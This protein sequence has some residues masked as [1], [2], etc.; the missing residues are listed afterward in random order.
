MWYYI[1]ISNY[2]H[3]YFYNIS[4]FLGFHFYCRK[5]I[6]MTWRKQRYV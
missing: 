1:S 3:I 2:F 6:F 4:T 5:N